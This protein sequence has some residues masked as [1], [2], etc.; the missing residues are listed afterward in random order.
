[1]KDWIEL[2]TERLLAAA[3]RSGFFADVIRDAEYF[4]ADGYVWDVAIAM[5]CKYWCS[6]FPKN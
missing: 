4:A 1:M 6:L 3:K 2:K 5:S